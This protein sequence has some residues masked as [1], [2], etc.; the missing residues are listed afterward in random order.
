[1]RLTLPSKPCSPVGRN[2]FK[3]AKDPIK[4]ST[5][6]IWG[7]VESL[8]EN[9][10]DSVFVSIILA[11]GSSEGATLMNRLN[12][13][14]R[15][16]KRGHDGRLAPRMFFKGIWKNGWQRLASAEQGSCW[17]NELRQQPRQSSNRS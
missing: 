17:A 5:N 16:A 6:P 10:G 15:F 11:K 14:R 13:K 7:R 9:E 8:L 3:L 1:M 4:R 2:R 12:P